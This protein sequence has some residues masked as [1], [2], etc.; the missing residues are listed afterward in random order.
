MK[1]EPR[2]FYLRSEEEMAALFP[3][4]PDALENTAKIAG[5]CNLDFEF[6]VHHLPEFKLPDGWTDGNAYFESLCTQGFARR[7]PRGSAEYRKRLQDE[8]AMIRKMDLWTIS[9]LSP[10]LSALQRGVG[11]GRTGRVRRG[12]MVSYCLISPMW[13]R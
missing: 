6:G 7:Y 4:C 10:I 5:L 12:V 13:T 1:Y 11:S 9:F 2:N 3:Q 8:M